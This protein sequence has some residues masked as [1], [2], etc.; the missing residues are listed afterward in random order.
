MPDRPK[1]KP[2][3]IAAKPVVVEPVFRIY[4]R[5][6]PMVEIKARDVTY[7][8]GEWFIVGTTELVKIQREKITRRW[9]GKST[10]ETVTDTEKRDTN[11]AAFR[12]ADI[13][14]VQYPD[15]ARTEQVQ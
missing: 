7:W 5:A 8:S 9:F 6:G 13:S 14:W 12:C 2:A 4:L 10:V 15:K 1:K 3:K 11:I